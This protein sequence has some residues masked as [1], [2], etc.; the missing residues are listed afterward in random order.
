MA[1]GMAGALSDCCALIDTAIY[2]YIY[3]HMHTDMIRHKSLFFLGIKFQSS[4]EM[5]AD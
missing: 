2:I 3:E 1:L 4:V 5:N